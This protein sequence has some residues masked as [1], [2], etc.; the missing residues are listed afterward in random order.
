[1]ETPENKKQ[2]L[3]TIK[4]YKSQKNYDAMLAAAQQALN[5]FR[6]D[7]DFEKLLHYAQA[8]YVD[9]KLH[10]QV[11]KELRQKK[12]Y[13]T[14]HGVYEKL[15]GVFPESTQLK[16]LLKKVEK[17]LEEARLE[18]RKEYFKQAE[19]KIKNLIKEDQL[20]AAL[21]ASYEILSYVPQNKHFIN[22]RN[23]IEKK[24]VQKINKEAE[25]YF[26][27]VIPELKLEYKNNKKA[28]LVI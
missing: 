24:R 21:Q 26:D 9:E 2:T 5:L 19:Q 27:K 1:M 7:E 11:V 16:K 20:D 18:E 28:F 15:M 6:G 23:K 3:A 22:L 17:E 25:L 4:A 14:L 8:H 12:D 13:Q 10:S